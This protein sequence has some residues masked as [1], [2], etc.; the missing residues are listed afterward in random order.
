GLWLGGFLW[1]AERGVRYPP[2]AIGPT[3]ALVVLTGGRE[4]LATGLELL[5]AGAAPRLFVSGVHPDVTVADLLALHGGEPGLSSRIDL[6]YEAQSTLGNA[7]E[8]AAWAA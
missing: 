4:R 3:E 2:P 6:G 5:A 7:R 8:T 1:F